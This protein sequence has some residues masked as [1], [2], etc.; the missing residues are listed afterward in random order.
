MVSDEKALCELFSEFEP[1]ST[2][3]FDQ[4]MFDMASNFHWIYVGSKR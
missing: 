3:Y 1:V 4:S 2:G